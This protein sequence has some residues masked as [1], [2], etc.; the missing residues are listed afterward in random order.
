M[1]R[2][3]EVTTA[4]AAW[5]AAIG[6]GHVGEGVP[7][8]WALSIREAAKLM[9]ICRTRVYSEI[10]SGALPARK[11]GKRTL[12]MI[13]DALEWLGRLPMVAPTRAN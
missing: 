3:C 5:A 1:N 8:P 9:G 12:I 4:Q 11:S 10:K 7:G 13:W 6:Q 2:Q